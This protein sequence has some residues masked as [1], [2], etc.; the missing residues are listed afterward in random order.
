M[1]KNSLLSTFEH[2]SPLTDAED[3]G[4]I[5]ESHS[6][7]TE[8]PSTGRSEDLGESERCPTSVVLASE[9][10][11]IL[12]KRGCGGFR[13]GRCG[14]KQ[15]KSSDVLVPSLK[16][17]G[18]WQAHKSLFPLHCLRVSSAPDA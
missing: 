3:S 7:S 17:F 14:N 5:V 11:G 9:G 1:E 10:S 6:C 16:H 2:V 18:S 8:S 15:L 13:V 12:V 4:P